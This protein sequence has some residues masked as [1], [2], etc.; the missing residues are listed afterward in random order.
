MISNDYEIK[1]SIK[2]HPLGELSSCITGDGTISLHSSLFQ[3]SFHDLNGAKT[4]ALRKFIEPAEL[5]RFKQEREIFVLDTCVG[6]GYN[7]ACLI[8]ALEN[9]SLY[10]NWW[11]LE[12]DQRPLQ[13]AIK[14]SLFRRSCSEKALD[15]LNKIITTGNWK[16]ED[17]EGNVL[18]GDARDKL[19]EIPKKIRFDLILLDPF[20]PNHCPELWSEEFL[21]SLSSKLTSKGRII[22]YSSAAAIR[23]SL[24]RAGL[25]LRT[26]K[27][28]T[29]SSHSWSE[30]T[31]AMIKGTLNC[32][33]KSNFPKLTTME[34]E[35]LLTK[36][37]IP[38]RDLNKKNASQ[39]II[40]RRRAEQEQSHLEVTSNWK[41]RWKILYSKNSL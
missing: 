2:S 1:E 34:E 15:I 6:L 4:E 21:N 13:F 3:E 23:G 17:G 20:S 27:P 29:K 38:Y 37:A 36:A 28:N 31:I 33:Q 7:S 41:R 11:G 8:E 5:E 35:H 9:R 12:I 14:S 32:A 24:R 22:T 25:E 40:N 16:I 18:W 19:G 30:G 10:L 26:I 39:E